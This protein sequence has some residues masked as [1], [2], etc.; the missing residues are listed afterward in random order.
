[1]GRK[2]HSHEES[3]KVIKMGIL[4]AIMV[5]MEIRKAELEEELRRKN[6]RKRM[7]KEEGE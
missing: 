3:K 5:K 7:V 6:E 1:M 4:E 2:I